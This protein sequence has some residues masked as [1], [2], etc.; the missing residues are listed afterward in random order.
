M[1]RITFL[2]LFVFL[3]YTVLAQKKGMPRVYFKH[4]AYL[5]PEQGNYIETQLLFD[6]QTFDFHRTDTGYVAS[7]QVTQLFKCGDTIVGYDKSRVQSLLVEDE[8]KK[9][10]YFIEKFVLPAGKYTYEMIVEDNFNVLQALNY[11]TPIELE[12]RKEV[13]DFSSITLARFYEKSSSVFQTV[14][15]KFGYDIVPSF[16]SHY[17]AF[18]DEMVYYTELY[19]LKTAAS[20]SVF[21]LQEQIINEKHDSIYFVRYSRIKSQD[22]YPLM[23]RLAIE[24]LPTGEYQLKLALIDR[25]KKELCKTTIGFTRKNTQKLNME[26][27]GNLALDN[28]YMYSIPID[29]SAYYV[30]SLIPIAQRTETKNIL[31]LLKR[32]D[33][34]LNMRYLQAFWTAVDEIHGLDEWLAYKKQV[35]RVE[36]NFSTNYQV[37][38]E[39]DRGRV[40]LQYGFPTQIYEVPSSPSEYPYEIWQYDKVQSFTNRRFIFYNTTNVTNDYRLLHSNMVGEIQNRRWRLDINKRNAFDND[41]DSDRGTGNRDHWGQNSEWYYNS[42]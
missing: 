7:F 40:F 15:T 37:G 12:D 19:N 21:V 30:A 27:L 18:L 20:D 31:K 34:Y 6:A 35:D 14:F 1:L 16:T 23:K 5:H 11:E 38:Y 9:N 33:N 41:L 26:E 28:E 2:I 42:Y 3:A 17:P 4:K 24:D 32:G 8:G 25:E 10:F 22:F 39:T 13:P 36:V 29:S